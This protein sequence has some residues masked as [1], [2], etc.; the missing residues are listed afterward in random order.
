MI[1]CFS[2]T[3]YPAILNDSLITITPN[4]LKTTNLIFLE[5]SKLKLE[6]L[7][8]KNQICLYDSIVYQYQKKDILYTNQ[9]NILTE[10]TKSLKSS[11]QD[12]EMTINR[13][14][15]YNKVVTIGGLSIGITLLLV[16]LV[17]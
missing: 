6:N 1:V 11:L 3:T 2:Q 8:L 12:K 7:E 13:L 5:H 4:Q 15:E 17:K 14:K 16:L 9:V 10:D